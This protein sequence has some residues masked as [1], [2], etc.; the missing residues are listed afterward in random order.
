M[1]HGYHHAV[2]SARRWG[3]TPDEFVFI[4]TWFDGSKEQMADFRHRALRHHLEGIWLSERLFGVTGDRPN[5]MRASRIHMRASR[6]KTQFP[7]AIQAVN[8]AQT[9]ISAD[10][11]DLFIKMR[12]FA[13]VMHASKCRNRDLRRHARGHPRAGATAVT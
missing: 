10:P 5:A 9:W 11:N 2:S 1:A 3:G 12:A 4:H 6:C 13:C 8:L 7:G